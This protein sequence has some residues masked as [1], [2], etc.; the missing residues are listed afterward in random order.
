MISEDVKNIFK[1]NKIGTTHTEQ[2]DKYSS[3]MKDKIKQKKN[4]GKQIA[5]YLDKNR[6]DKLDNF[7]NGDPTITKQ[8]IIY[9]LIDTYI[10]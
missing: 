5:L 2:V 7:I 3:S 9:Y 10:Q 4:R 1:Q 6:E 8:Q